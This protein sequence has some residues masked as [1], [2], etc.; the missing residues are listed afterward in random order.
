VS[1]QERFGRTF[2]KGHVIFREG[3]A[4][5]EMFVIQAG[6]IRLTREIRGEDQFVADLGAGEFFGEMSILNLKPRSATAT[7]VEDTQVLALGPKTFEAMIKANTE[8]AVRMI[9]KLAARLDDANDRIE[10]LMLRDVNSRVVHQ[11]LHLVRSHGQTVGS[12]VE[13]AL[14]VDTI[15]NV[16]GVD[17]PKVE[18]VLARMERSQLV[19]AAGARF[20]VP[21]VGKLEEFLEFLEMR[22]RFGE[23]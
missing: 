6:K 20:R 15:A 22:E 19:R 11:I 16:A 18:A 4:G 12:E 1:L 2:P 13:V 10:N 17:A 23:I 9:K 21:N 14:P 8:I 3:D 7:V 5:Q